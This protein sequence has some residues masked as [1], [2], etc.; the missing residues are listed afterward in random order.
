[1]K[2]DTEGKRGT[3]WLLP[4]LLLGSVWGLSEVLL[5]GVLRSSLPPL[6]A[7]IL[8][9][10]GMG[11]M[12]FGYGIKLRP[13][14]MPALALVTAATMQMAVPILQCSPLCRA[15]SGL[16]VVLHGAALALFLPL[17]GR[18]GG[19]Y[20]ARL[21]ALGFSA[22]AVSSLLFFYAGPHLAPCSYLLSFGGEGGLV[23]F[24]LREG[25]VWSLFSAVML[26]AGVMAGKRL[27]DD[28][29]A[30]KSDAPRVFFG[31]SAASLGLCLALIAV[32]IRM[33]F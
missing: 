4:I 21:G 8:T 26:P 10:I 14:L 18:G 17:A 1:M 24:L 15:N 27:N 32:C 6:R 22:A 19:K 25:A 12:G 33:G 20:A 11:I 5:G 13:W 31:T 28:I 23:R 29:A 3:H 16:A 30:W 9:G 2:N 7:G